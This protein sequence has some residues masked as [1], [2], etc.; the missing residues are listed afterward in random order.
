MKKLVDIKPADSEND[1]INLRGDSTSPDKHKE[2]QRLK[3]HPKK[4]FFYKN[5]DPINHIEDIKSEKKNDVNFSEGFPKRKIIP[6]LSG[7]LRIG[8]I[9]L[10]LLILINILNLYQQGIEL[11][12]EISDTAQKGYDYLVT[13]GKDTSKIQF[14]EAVKAFDNAKLNFESAQNTLWFYKNDN[15]YYGKKDEIGYAIE[16]LLES[17][18]HFSIAGKQFISALD[19]FNK[20][21]VYFVEKNIP[22]A[23][24]EIN[25]QPSLTELLNKGM[26]KTKIAI[27]EISQANEKIN[28]INLDVLPQEIK[29]KL[30]FAK[31]KLNIISTTLISIEKEFPALLKLLGDKLPHR[32]LIL[33]QNNN[34]IRPTGGFIGS[35]AIVDINDGYIEKIETHDV[36]A[37]DNQYTEIIEAPEDLQSFIQNWRFR[38]S[39]YS[40]DFPES[41]KKAIW[42]LTKEGGPS[43][44]TVIAINQG[45]L[46]DLL[47]IT[48]PIKVDD[49]ATFDSENYSFLLSYLVEGKVLSQNDPKI[50]LKQFIPLFKE[51]IIKPQNISKVSLKLYRAI[52]QK[53]ILMY[54]TDEEIQS[55]FEAT[56]VSGKAYRNEAN[57]DYLSV[58]NFSI[59]GTKSDQFIE[60]KIL[61]ESFI[62]ENGEVADQITI[63]REHKWDDRILQSWKKILAESGYKN[64]SDGLIDILGRGKNVVITKVYVPFGSKLVSSSGADIKQKFDEVLHKT[65]FVYTT[66]ATV[67]KPSKIAINYV[68]PYKLN[69][70]Q[71]QVYKIIAEKQPGSR[72]SILTKIISV[73]DSLKVLDSY[74]VQ[75]QNTSDKKII[76]ASNLVYDRYFS[77]LLY[78]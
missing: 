7:I 32:Y 48:G 53:H 78:K 5:I 15:S 55:L 20:I 43:V 47:D 4:H 44:D 46:R 11:K 52:Q 24:Y 77:A 12:K 58:I 51:A 30:I 19:D 33:L 27:G 22:K 76:Y 59:G 41:A 39:N 8:L 54:S 61:H 42:F 26:E 9:G 63:I 74:P 69:F 29:T 6:H 38:D 68:L 21:P 31:D 67:Q 36:Y 45:L 49:F 65:Y 71:P 23:I 57:E 72:G 60:E 62:K 14:E 10:V 17:G 28:K 70:S 37:L 3:L 40:Y 13:A 2:E 56:G 34:E 73:E 66:E 50:V 16:S 25:N 64:L 1:K 35:Y 75:D 18:K